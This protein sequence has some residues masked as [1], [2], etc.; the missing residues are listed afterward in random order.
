[1]K[2]GV[3]QNEWRP[4]FAWC[5]VRLMNGQWIWLKTV[6]RTSYWNKEVESDVCT[7]NFHSYVCREL[8]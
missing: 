6:E 7:N 2:W 5:P 8:R 4:W 1:M 3:S